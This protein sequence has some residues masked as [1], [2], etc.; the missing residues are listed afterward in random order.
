MS[1]KSGL[2]NQPTIATTVNTAK[3]IQ[4]MSV[5]ETSEPKKKGVVIGSK[6]NGKQGYADTK[7]GEYWEVLPFIMGDDSKLQKCLL[8][9]GK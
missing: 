1:N 5:G 4:S 9:K 8:N 6:F 2:L 3:R 7:T